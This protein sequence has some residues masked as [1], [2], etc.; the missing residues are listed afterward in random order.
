MNIFLR[1]WSI[2]FKFCKIQLSLSLLESKS[3]H[4]WHVGIVECST[5]LGLLNGLVKSIA[6]HLLWKHKMCN[7]CNNAPPVPKY[8]GFNRQVNLFYSVFQY[9]YFHIYTT[10]FL[11]LDLKQ[12][13]KSWKDMHIHVYVTEITADS[14]KLYF[15]YNIVIYSPLSWYWKRNLWSIIAQCVNILCLLG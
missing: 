10:C 15:K 5:F 14:I 13:Y 1:S 8:S 4:S 7:A 6:L 12:T 11:Y 3:I 9:S 2:D